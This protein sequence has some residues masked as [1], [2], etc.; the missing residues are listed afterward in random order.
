MMTSSLGYRAS[1]QWLLDNDDTQ[2]LDDENGSESV[3]LALV[4][5]IFGKK[6]GQATA[7][8]RRL[9]QRNEIQAGR[10][11]SAALARID[12]RRQVQLA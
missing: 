12:K 7:D 10:I 11:T 1:L 5:D 6:D 8:L 4:S 9:R 3:T 2:W